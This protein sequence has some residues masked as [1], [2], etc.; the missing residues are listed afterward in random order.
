MKALVCGGRDY[1]NRGHVF[2]VLD[3]FM[4]DEIV[5]GGA[6]G[7]D[8]L[9]MAWARKKG[10]TAHVY[11]PNWEELGR[12]AGPVRNQDMLDKEKPDIVIVFPG[13]RGTDDMIRRAQKSYNVGGVWISKGA[14]ADGYEGWE[15]ETLSEV[16]YGKDHKQ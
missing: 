14:K 11:Y 2:H 5:C 10:R 6:S 13:G 7:A 8:D 9:A 1:M 4:P 12:A 16:S 3:M 15:L